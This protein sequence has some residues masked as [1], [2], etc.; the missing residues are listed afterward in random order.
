M[1]PWYFLGFVP[2]GTFYA[3][4]ISNEPLIFL[5][6]RSFPN[7]LRFRD[8]KYAPDIFEA[9]FLPERFMLLRFQMNLCYFWGVVPSRMFYASTILSRGYR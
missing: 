1:S 3:F 4:T 9:S 6:L 7:V 8:F 5:R 2:S